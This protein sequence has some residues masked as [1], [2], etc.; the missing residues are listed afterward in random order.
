[1]LVKACFD[2]GKYLSSEKSDTEDMLVYLASDSLHLLEGFE[3]VQDSEDAEIEFVAEFIRRNTRKIDK[4]TYFITYRELEKKLNSFGF[5][6]KNPDNNYID[7]VSA[8]D[9]RRIL[10][11]GFPGWSRQVAK[12]DMRKILNEC[13]LDV[14]HGIDAEVFFHN[15]DPIYFFASDYRA[16]IA[17]LAFR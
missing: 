3:D 14:G 16:Q 10:R 12:G 11:T 7:I 2:D 15:E 4:R 5:I 17:S 8:V 9:G 1:V 6:M 13:N